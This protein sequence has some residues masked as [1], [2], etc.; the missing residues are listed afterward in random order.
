MAIEFYK[1]HGLKCT[2]SYNSDCDSW[3]P[4]ISI[5]WSEGA[6]SHF[7]TF[8]GP[9]RSFA[10]AEDAIACGFTLARAWVDKRL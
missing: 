6:N 4:N 9:P 7:H 5:S 3:V 8:D 10:T 1:G 2:S